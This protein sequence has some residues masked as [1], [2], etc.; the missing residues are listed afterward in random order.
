MNYLGYNKDNFVE[1]D[2][3]IDN[4]TLRIND[5]ILPSV[6]GAS[7]DVLTMDENGQNT[8]FQPAPEPPTTIEKPIQNLFTMLTPRTS[9][10]TGNADPY[11]TAS[12]GSEVIDTTGFSV[13]D[14]IRVRVEGYYVNNAPDPIAVPC[15]IVHQWFI[16]W[17]NSSPSNETLSTPVQFNGSGGNWFN[18]IIFT[19]ESESSV[20][21]T[22]NGKINYNTG[23]AVSDDVRALNWFVGG[24]APPGTARPKSI[25]APYYF[26]PPPSLFQIRGQNRTDS[27]DGYALATNYYIDK[28]N[29]DALTSGGGS[30]SIDHLSLSNLNA[31]SGSGDVDAGHETLVCL[32]GRA[33]GQQITGG[34]GT[35]TLILKSNDT[36][37]LINNIE[38]G[39]GLD[40]K[41]HK[42]F[43][44]SVATPLVIEHESAVDKID[45]RINNN[46]KVEVKDTEIQLNE[47]LNMNNNQ[48]DN[49]SVI[50][51]GLGSLSL[52]GSSLV[53][54]IQIDPNPIQGILI[55]SNVGTS[56]ELFG[57]SETNLNS[58]NNIN[59]NA[60]ITTVNAG[61][62]PR[63]VVDASEV[64]IG[65]TLNMNDNEIIN[66][67]NIRTNI[68]PIFTINKNGSNA[69]EIYGNSTIRRVQISNGVYL[70]SGTD[71]FCGNNDIQQ[72]GN[73]EVSTINGFT[74]V[75]GIFAGT[76]D[77]LTLT[78]STV[79]Q[80]ILPTA[81][82][83]TVSVP[84][85]GFQIGDSF[86]CVL[87][88]DFGSNN[89]DTLTI[90]LKGGP[91]S[92]IILASLVVPLNNSSASS[93]EV[94]IDFQ[95]RNIGGAGVADICS[96][97]DFT[98][99]QSG[100]GGAF[101]GE[102]G[103]FQNNTTFDTTLLNTL[104]ITA[105]FSSASASNTIK[106]IVSKLSKDF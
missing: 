24:S 2:S 103:T 66:C 80:S 89:S 68:S 75:G 81:F 83:G 54:G 10:T 30:P 99:N 32:D 58:N 23:F 98:Y 48:I 50:N 41:I 64:S 20:R 95:L 86:H 40:T 71:L 14:A 22:F 26:Y 57:E 77:S 88:G 63:V 53:S 36:T 5:Y 3:G 101:V 91:T 43:S 4:G 55:G 44:N 62:L 25:G 35:G 84:P 73:L 87:S 33:G 79:E 78:A 52:I 21:I 74:P 47:N 92:T 39:S 11:W 9:Y 106:T 65:N 19:W 76:A 97:F 46:N 51:N 34:R 31:A 16:S 29:V 18:E 13:G 105:Q 85:N 104:E 67:N 12:S 6:A 60:P 27:G 38:L 72:C 17:P 49:V 1:G 93:F 37:P 42:I 28:M 8:S 90:R 94:E 102:R 70:L 7:G 96:N 69:T 100:G 61:G 45:L 56:I 15:T 82:V 59:L